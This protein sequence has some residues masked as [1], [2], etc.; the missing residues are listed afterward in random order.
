MNQPHP[1]LLRV[2]TIMPDL[3]IDEVEHNQEGL[4]NDILI[5]NHQWVFRFA[6][7]ERFAR[8]M[9]EEMRI[10]EMIRPQ[11]G[12]DLPRPYLRGADYVV[13]SYLPGRPFTRNI[14]QVLD[15]TSR[16]QLAS[17][18]GEFLAT[19][20][21]TDLSNPGW[22]IP[23]TLA[24]VTRERWLALYQRIKEKV[25]PLLLK[26]QME[27]AE[28]LLSGF[29]EDP[30]SFEYQPALI[31]GDLAPY[32]ILYNAETQRISA[33]IDFGVAGIGD[34]ALDIGSL[35]QIY[36]ES[37]VNGM[38]A[39]YPDLQKILPRARFYAQSIELQWVLQGLESG[40]TFWY[41]AHLGGAR[42]LE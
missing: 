36:G 40:E 6:K 29:L 41:T 28:E 32:H 35:I 22:K 12:V 13:Y 21:T 10:L 38:Q 16:Q 8:I 15:E 33:V 7:N 4:I 27:W 19:L 34:A 30:G 9:D 20:H 1:L 18:M 26:H 11:I 14:L 23:T 42:D 24:P 3:V 25:F 2:Q 17:Q 37:F 39:T 31:H 5:I